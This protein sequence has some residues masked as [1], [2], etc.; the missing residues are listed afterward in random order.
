MTS[1]LKSIADAVERLA[2]AHDAGSTTF[3][4]GDGRTLEIKPQT[5]GTVCIDCYGSTDQ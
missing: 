3:D 4:V 1:A 5:D 2:C